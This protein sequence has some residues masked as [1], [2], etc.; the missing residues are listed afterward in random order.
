MQLSYLYLGPN[1]LV[2]TVPESWSSLGQV[3]RCHQS[4]QW[5]LLV[6]SDQQS[7]KLLHTHLGL[8]KSSSLTPG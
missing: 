3:S 4:L 5:L 2:V 8:P 6:L 7:Q 1:Q